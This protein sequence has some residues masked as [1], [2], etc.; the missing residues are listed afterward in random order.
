MQCVIFHGAFGSKE[1]NWFPW[2]KKELISLSHEVFLDQYPVD[3]WNTIEA[4]GKNNT[5]TIQNLAS[6]VTFFEKSTLPKL[7][8]KKDIVFIGHSLSPVFILH[9]VTM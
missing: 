8:R 4:K 3:D 5:I 7:D 2:L 1:G 6:W 9:L